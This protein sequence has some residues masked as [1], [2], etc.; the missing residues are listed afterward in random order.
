MQKSPEYLQDAINSVEMDD[1]LRRD[2]QERHSTLRKK[3]HNA[4]AFLRGSHTTIM[5][6][7]NQMSLEPEKR[8]L[9]SYVSRLLRENQL[10]HEKLM[11]KEEERLN[12]SG[13]TDTEH[14]QDDNLANN[15]NERLLTSQDRVRE[16]EASLRAKEKQIAAQDS[17]ILQIK[18]SSRN[19]DLIAR[20][21]ISELQNVIA[22]K[23]AHI[24]NQETIIRQLKESPGNADNVSAN[25]E[26]TDLIHEKNRMEELSN[27]K[28][29]E[30]ESSLALL[31]EKLNSTE[32]RVTDLTELAADRK[33]HLK[34][35][36]TQIAQLHEKVSKSEHLLMESQKRALEL[37]KEC[38]EAKLMIAKIQ[39]DHMQNRHELQEQLLEHKQQSKQEQTNH[40]VVIVEGNALE[41]Q[42]QPRHR[43]SISN[44]KASSLDPEA[45]KDDVADIRPPKD[46]HH[47]STSQP[48]SARSRPA[49]LTLDIVGGAFIPPP[50]SPYGPP[51]TSTPN[52]A[53]SNNFSPRNK[54]SPTHH[55]FF[56][57]LLNN[58]DDDNESV[59][60]SEHNGVALK[61]LKSAAQKKGMDDDA[62][63]EAHEQMVEE[64]MFET[65]R[66]AQ[67]IEIN[68]MKELLALLRSVDNK[69]F[70]K[71]NE[72]ITLLSN[73]N[74]DYEHVLENEWWLEE[75]VDPE[76]AKVAEAMYDDFI[77][78]QTVSIWYIRHS[79]KIK[80]LK[81]LSCEFI[82]SFYLK[83]TY[84]FLCLV[85]SKHA[86]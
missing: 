84:L 43:R 35:A 85:R 56:R 47:P 20:Q 24:S 82:V 15:L 17:Y 42:E 8:S 60:N 45:Y 18:E 6:D 5:E 46:P 30:L 69:L 65:I 25:S 22:A 52:S 27:A 3:L 37:E 13:G 68:G 16:L 23:E 41:K 26:I 12:S 75:H 2:L 44:S 40:H 62:D 4:R 50:V 21:R 83:Y 54:V 49:G 38:A 14:D 10:L 33:E 51:S 66:H 77:R 48:N 19:D 73:W 74:P 31:H 79:Q 86:Y 76:E 72:L 11:R 71:K 9:E 80:Y 39:Q 57:P 61:T 64:Q 70:R 59:A 32:K 78:L 81:K 67:Q 1:D 34:D 7:Q 55:S 63:H 28:I 29:L 58:Q 36:N 53:R